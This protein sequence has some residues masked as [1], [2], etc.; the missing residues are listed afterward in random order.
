LAHLD[1][2]SYFIESVSDHGY[3]LTPFCYHMM[4][5]GRRAAAAVAYN[6]ETHKFEVSAYGDIVTEADGNIYFKPGEQVSL[7]PGQRVCFYSQMTWERDSGRLRG[8]LDDIGAAVALVLAAATLADYNVELM[9]GLTDEEEGVAAAGNQTI[10]RGGARLLRYFDQPELVIASDIHEAVPM[11]EGNGPVGLEPGDG[12]C[13]AEK[14]SRGRGVVTPPHLYQLQRQLAPELA[15][16][17]IRLRENIGGYIGR[18]EGI[19]AML[20]TPNVALIGFL[21]ENRHF[22]KDVTSANIKDLVDLARVV[23]CYVLLT[24]TP[25][26]R[27]VMGL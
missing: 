12:A 21:G 13:F 25:I 9:L 3:L 19:N 6:L 2:I 4:H 26:W 5:P 15:A 17:G 18:T 10:G 23:V 16:E 11:L 27:E 8:S 1:I 22:E 7:H 20:R 14:A 24:Q